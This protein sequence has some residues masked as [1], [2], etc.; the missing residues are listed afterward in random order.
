MHYQKFYNKLVKKKAQRLFKTLGV[1]DCLQ[2]T[3]N[4]S[5][6]SIYA[7]FQC[8]FAVPSVQR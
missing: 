1:V 7:P 6:P 3:H 5:P 8:D 2:T 4:Y